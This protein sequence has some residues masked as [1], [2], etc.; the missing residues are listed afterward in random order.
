VLAPVERR[1]LA[2]VLE[3]SQALGLLGPGSTDAHVEH[4]CSL[5]QA[6]GRAPHRFLD[7]GSGAGVPGLALA[8]AWPDAVATLLDARQRAVD[9]L[10]RAVAELG[11]ES[12][13]GIEL[14]RAEELARRE[15][16]R[17]R[18]DLVVARGFGS[19]SVTAECGVGF[20]EAGGELLVTEPP[21]DPDAERWPALG[22]QE[23]GLAPPRRIRFGDAG[24]VVLT[25]IEP[26]A[27]RW[28]RRSGI[29]RKRPVWRDPGAA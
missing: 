3:H 20:L 28:P 11:L 5:A 21:G 7:L 9:A 4:A 15:D 19:P 25:A 26:A 14:G 23:L 27:D 16:L 12:R 6:L 10:R 22:L 13:V 8:L 17:G 18:Y 2:G 24:A 1:A 29:P